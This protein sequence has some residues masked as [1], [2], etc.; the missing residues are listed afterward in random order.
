MLAVSERPDV[1]L[2][3][4]HLS[5]EDGLTLCWRLKRLPQPPRV[6]IYSAFA[7]AKLGLLARVAGADGVLDKGVPTEMLFD[8][9]RH[10]ARG[11]RCEP[12]A[13]PELMTDIAEALEAEDVAIFGL[14]A[15][16]VSSSEAAETLRL[17]YHDLDRKVLRILKRLRL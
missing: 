10:L 14:L 13:T 2:I 6:L 4:Y 8:T 9:I 11:E 1:A 16:R 5:D 7:D 3:D 17:D 15:N 12:Q